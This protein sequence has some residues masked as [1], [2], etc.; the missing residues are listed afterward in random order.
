MTSRTTVI[1]YMRAASV[2]SSR[3]PRRASGS[4]AATGSSRI[5]SSGRLAIAM[6]EGDL[7]TLPAGQPPRLLLHVQPQPGDPVRRVPL[8]PA[9]VEADAEPQVVGD[10]RTA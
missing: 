6:S 1:Q 8:V 9:G 3:N 10:N 2:R 7:G 4:S 5:S